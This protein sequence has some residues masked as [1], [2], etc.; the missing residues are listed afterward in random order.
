MK[1]LALI[2]LVFYLGSLL[3]AS[4]S[5]AARNGLEAV[6][7]NQP[8]GLSQLTSVAQPVKP[9]DLSADSDK[10]L[11]LWLKFECIAATCSA[12]QKLTSSYAAASIRRFSARAPPLSVA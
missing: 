5:S 3:M 11:V 1:H 10:A 2:A 4:D 12:K 8:H 9:A 6:Q 7:A